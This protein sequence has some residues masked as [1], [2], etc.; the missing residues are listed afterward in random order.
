MQGHVGEFQCF[1]AGDFSILHHSRQGNGKRFSCG[2]RGLPANFSP[3]V[4][5]VLGLPASLLYFEND[6]GLIVKDFCA[7]GKFVC[8][9]ENSIHN[10]TRGA[11]GILCDDVLHAAAAKMFI[12]GVAGVNNAITKKDEYIAWLGVNCEFVVRNLFKH[13]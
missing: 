13:A 4:S 7:C 12:F 10:F 8:R 2:L 11:A 3:V 1:F 6:R 9:L 5:G